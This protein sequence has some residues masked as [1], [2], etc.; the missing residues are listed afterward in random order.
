MEMD[1]AGQESESVKPEGEAKV[2]TKQE[3]K[4]SEE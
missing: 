2:E 4:K 3:E 1:M